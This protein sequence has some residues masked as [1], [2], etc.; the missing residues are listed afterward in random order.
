MNKEFVIE[1]NDLTTGYGQHAVTSHIHA[2]LRPGQLISLLGPNGVGKSTLLRTLGAFQ[3]PL[4]GE[5]RVGGQPIGEMTSAQLSRIIGVVLTERPDIQNMPVR[6][7]VSMG[8]SPYTGFWGRLTPEDETLVD[9][10][11]QQTWV[12]DLSDRMI[13][14]LSD[15]ERQKVMIAKALAQHTPIILLDEPTAFLDFPSKVEMMRLLGRLAHQMQKII[16]L[17]THDVEMALQ[18]SD[19]LWLMTKEGITTGTPSQLA[20]DGTI[21]RFIQ[22]EGVLF[23]AATLT[24][25]VR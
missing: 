2:V 4:G 21:A 10:A 7:M 15:G 24:L 8:R 1:L 23:D 5:I 11:M 18:L 20:Q 3:P 6:D 17:S 14:T 12:T 16:F 19:S 25:R 13:N 9:E 22:C